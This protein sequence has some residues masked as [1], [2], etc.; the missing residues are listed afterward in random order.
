MKGHLRDLPSCGFSGGE[1]L[2]KT[3]CSWGREED[4]NLGEEYT[5]KCKIGDLKATDKDTI[6]LAPGCE[7]SVCCEEKRK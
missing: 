7:G 4:T 6:A 3:F 1:Q 2:R 5:L